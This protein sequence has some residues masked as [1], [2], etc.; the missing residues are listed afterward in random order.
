M[1]KEN[2]YM[3]LKEYKINLNDFSIELELKSTKTDGSLLLIHE[4]YNIGDGLNDF[5]SVQLKHGH[6]ELR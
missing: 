5:L 2:S 1:F 6:V 4:I 3:E